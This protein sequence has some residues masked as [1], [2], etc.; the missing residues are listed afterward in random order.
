MALGLAFLLA[1]FEAP[2]PDFKMSDGSVV[3]GE[4][5]APNDDGTVIR[6][7]SGGLTSRIAWERF[8]QQT[9][10]ELV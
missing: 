10:V 2:A 7:A 4:L 3:T 9:L 1:G 5:V 8:A 6:R